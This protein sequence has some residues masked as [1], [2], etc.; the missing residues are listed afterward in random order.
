MRKPYVF[1]LLFVGIT[2]SVIIPK[3][4]PYKVSMSKIDRY[5]PRNNGYFADALNR[6]QTFRKRAVRGTEKMDN[7]Y[8]DE[9]MNTVS[10]PIFKRKKRAAGNH[11]DQLDNYDSGLSS[12]RIFKKNIMQNLEVH[13]NPSVHKLDNFYGSALGGFRTFKRSS[14]DSNPKLELKLKTKTVDDARNKN[15]EDWNKF[16]EMAVFMSLI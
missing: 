5:N 2:N 1:I 13:E 9:F 6:F 10:L 4:V 7:E 11:I 3:V 16:I 8:Y 15:R 12:F 14:E